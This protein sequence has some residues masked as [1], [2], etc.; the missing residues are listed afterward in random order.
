VAFSSE[1]ERFLPPRKGSRYVLRMLRELLYLRP[2]HAGT[3][4]A[5]VLD[6]T[7]HVLRR[8]STVF[9]ISDFLDQ[10][11]EA[12]LRVA[13]RRHEIVAVSLADPRELELP[14]LGLIELED[15]ES[16]R[17]VLVDTSDAALR[18]RYH[19]DAVE[20]RARR[21]HLLASLGVDHIHLQTDR[22]YVEPLVAF[23]RRRARI[24]NRA[25]AG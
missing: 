1:I 9:L 23:F 14:D 25:R 11:Y 16:G 20:Q 18:Q 5:T 22:S 6:Y 15:A 21:D 13:A 3:S 7:N 17:R 19:D 8:R 4:L 10:G 2:A 24:A 12:L